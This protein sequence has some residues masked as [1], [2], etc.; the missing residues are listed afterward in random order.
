MHRGL[1]S[2]DQ[3]QK[4]QIQKHIKTFP[5]N[6]PSQLL[7]TTNDIL[8]PLLQKK[9]HLLS[10]GFLVAQLVELF[11]EIEQ[12]ILFNIR[13]HQSLANVQNTTK[14]FDGDKQN[15]LCSPSVMKER[16]IQE[17]HSEHNLQ[18]F[19][20]N[21]QRN[22]EQNEMNVNT[23]LSKQICYKDP[24]PFLRVLGYVSY[25]VSHFESTLSKSN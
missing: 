11:D 1:V 2:F 12:T 24:T 5:V 15:E 10:F 21:Q 17:T 9:L 16:D 8:S 25:S 3:Q 7:T 6:L 19:A 14:N 23:S 22:D 18:N 4:Q 20:T 13:R